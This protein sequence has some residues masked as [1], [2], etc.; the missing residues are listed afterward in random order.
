MRRLL[1]VI[2]AD[3]LVGAP[4]DRAPQPRLEDLPGLVQRVRE[5]G[6]PVSYAIEGDP[7]KVPAG[8]AVCAYRIVQEALSNVVRHSGAVAAR[9]ELRVSDSALD[10]AVDNVLPRRPLP[11]HRWRGRGLAEIANGLP[12]S[13]AGWRPGPCQTVGSPCTRSALGTPVTHPGPA[14]RRPAV[15]PARFRVLL[16]VQPDLEVV[17]EAADGLLAVAEARRL[18]P[19]IVFMDIRMPRLDG[20]EATRTIT[21][22]LPGTRVIPDHLRLGRV[23]VRRAAGRC[24]RVPAEGR[25]DRR[26]ANAVRTVI[27]GG[28]L[29]APT[30]TLRMIS[31]FARS[32]GPAQRDRVL[33]S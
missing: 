13:T 30:V 9:V 18:R 32:P 17:G 26:T 31:Q 2:R 27:D 22:V 5:A 4:G 15:G 23:R 16:D 6:L 20:I 11:R 7:D 19:D 25:A 24:L 28:A 8:V 21:A 3:G 12:S 1:G 29:L 10:V 14:R 33:A